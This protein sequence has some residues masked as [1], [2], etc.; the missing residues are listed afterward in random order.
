[1]KSIFLALALGLL[2]CVAATPVQPAATK[3]RKLASGAVFASLSPLY[4]VG[5]SFI[6]PLLSKDYVGASPYV[7]AETGYG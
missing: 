4:H 2:G 6:G 3:R 5:L 7:R 1:M